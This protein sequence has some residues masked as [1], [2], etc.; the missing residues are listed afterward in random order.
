[1]RFLVI[2]LFQFS[3]DAPNPVSLK[4]ITGRDWDIRY[5]QTA[6]TK[7]LNTSLEDW[8]NNGDEKTMQAFD[9][10]IIEISK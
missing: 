7:S 6:L 9:Q 3:P 2:Y 10:H 4:Q 1:L 8:Q 5:L